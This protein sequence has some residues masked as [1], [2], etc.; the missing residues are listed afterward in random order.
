MHIYLKYIIYII[1]YNL[2]FPCLYLC[3]FQVCPVKAKIIYLSQVVYLH[4][5]GRNHSLIKP[6][7][8]MFYKTEWSASHFHKWTSW[9]LNLQYFVLLISLHAILRGVWIKSMH[10]YIFYF[11][12]SNF[13]SSHFFFHESFSFINFYCILPWCILRNFYTC[14]SNCHTTFSP[15]TFKN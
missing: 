9:S 14:K 1:Q 8:P 3:I 15:L 11:P 6:A 13:C 5:S 7:L 10:K 12:G 2:P 4:F